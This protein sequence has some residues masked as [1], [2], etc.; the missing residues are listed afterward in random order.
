MRVERYGCEP[1]LHCL[2]G[3][4][5]VPNAHVLAYAE[6]CLRDISDAFAHLDGWHR[7]CGLADVLY[8]L[9][10]AVS[11]CATLDPIRAWNA[12]DRACVALARV[13]DVGRLD[14]NYVSMLVEGLAGEEMNARETLDEAR[15]DP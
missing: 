6:W 13:P 10:T 9:G 15:T 14:M 4:P 3:G 7:F 5:L 1:L 12:V 2:P 8:A 11:A